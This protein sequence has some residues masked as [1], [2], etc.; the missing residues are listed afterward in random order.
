MKI[1]IDARG[2]GAVTDEA[3]EKAVREITPRVAKTAKRAAPVRTRG[4]SDSVFDEYE[5][6]GKD[7]E[8]RVGSNADHVDGEGVRVG[9]RGLYNELGTSK[10]RAQPWLKPALYQTRGVR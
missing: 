1:R 5:G 8:G 3:A 7:I 6:E 4:L 10:M 9:N 2:L